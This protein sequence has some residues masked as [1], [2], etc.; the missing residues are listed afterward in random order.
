MT[1]KQDLIQNIG[2]I[3]VKSRH[4]MRPLPSAGDSSPKPR[5]PELA[6][7]FLV[8]FAKG[9]LIREKHRYD[10]LMKA[11]QTRRTVSLQ[12]ARSALARSLWFT[13]SVRMTPFA[14]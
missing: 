13:P 7:C 6:A 12:S 4:W 14:S 11:I 2:S 8:F 9:R 1:H 5:R 3:S 10:G